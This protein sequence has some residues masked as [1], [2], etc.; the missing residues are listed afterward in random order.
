MKML[1]YTSAGKEQAAK[2][3][4]SEPTDMI[5]PLGN[6]RALFERQIG[7][8]QSTQLIFTHDLW[9]NS[10]A[11]AW[12]DTETGKRKVIYEGGFVVEYTVDDPNREYSPPRPSI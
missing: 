4:S 11:A 5:R 1:G 8:S 9:L 7:T 10:A 6:A 12:Y 3:L 2:R